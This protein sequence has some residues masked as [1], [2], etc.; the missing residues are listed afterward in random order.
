MVYLQFQ[1]V[2]HVNPNMDEGMGAAAWLTI[3]LIVLAIATVVG[4]FAWLIITRC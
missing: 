2:H 4:S 1:G 3:I